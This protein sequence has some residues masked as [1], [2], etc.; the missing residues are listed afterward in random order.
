M[1]VVVTQADST[2][3]GWITNINTT[4][5]ESAVSVTVKETNGMKNEWK[6]N[7]WTNGGVVNVTGDRLDLT[8]VRESDEKYFIVVVFIYLHCFA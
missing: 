1:L 2:T 7:T 5:D 8:L 4:K 6:T 3:N